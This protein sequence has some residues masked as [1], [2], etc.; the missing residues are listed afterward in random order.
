MPLQLSL[1]RTCH[2]QMASARTESGTDWSRLMAGSSSVQRRDQHLGCGHNVRLGRQP[3]ITRWEPNQRRRCRV[4][5][6]GVQSRFAAEEHVGSGLAPSGRVAR[7]V[8][9][10]ASRQARLPPNHSRTFHLGL[11]PL[12]AKL[13]RLR[14]VAQS[15]SALEWGSRGR[16]FESFRP[17][18]LS[19][20]FSKAHATA[21]R[22]E[23]G[24][25]RVFWV[26]LLEASRPYVSAKQRAAFARHPDPSSMP[27]QCNRDSQCL[28]CRATVTSVQPNHV[29]GGGPRAMVLV[30]VPGSAA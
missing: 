17:D 20:A 5:S 6:R 21:K 8:E 12:A 22:A 29:R 10:P 2:H 28:V 27:Q 1:I 18:Q 24:L 13:T 19:R 11:P 4:P 30:L 26:A 23:Q 14:G 16:R 15:G 9:P 3:E 7:Q 25:A